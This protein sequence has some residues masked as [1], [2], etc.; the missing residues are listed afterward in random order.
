M[1]NDLFYGTVL[2]HNMLLTFYGND[3]I[4]IFLNVISDALMKILVRNYQVWHQIE[5]HCSAT[6]KHRG[7]SKLQ[8]KGI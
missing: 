3:L 6:R 5:A 1:K 7:H 4:L 8:Y 2:V